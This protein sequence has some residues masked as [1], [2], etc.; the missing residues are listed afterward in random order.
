MQH[1]SCNISSSIFIFLYT[2]S[3]KECQA[4][5]Y[6]SIFVCTYCCTRPLHSHYSADR[7][8]EASSSDPLGTCRPC[9]MYASATASGVAKVARVYKKHCTTSA[10]VRCSTRLPSASDGIRC[11]FLSLE[12][13]RNHRTA[14]RSSTNRTLCPILSPSS[15]QQNPLLPARF[16][17]F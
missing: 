6:R 16:R 2:F 4:V 10:A 12:S 15:I 3:V 1:I 17:L 8:C 7:L 11:D 14:D 13:H 5:L 9:A